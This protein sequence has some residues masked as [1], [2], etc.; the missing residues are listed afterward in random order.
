MKLIAGIYI[1]VD[2]ENF[3][4]MSIFLHLTQ[5]PGTWN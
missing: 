3:F 4:L 5:K 1:T 2:E